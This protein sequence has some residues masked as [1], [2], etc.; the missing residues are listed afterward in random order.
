MT[1][2]IWK[3]VVGHE[4]SY[5]VSNLGRV[6]SL[7]RVAVRRIGKGP[8]PDRKSQYIIPGKILRPGKSSNG[9]FTVSI[10]GWSYCLHDL[11]LTAFRGPRPEA[12]MDACHDDGVKPNNTLGNLRWDTRKGNHADKIK[13]GT[14][15]RGLD[16]P[17]AKLTPDTVREIRKFRGK[18]SQSALASRFNVSP[19][20]VQ[21]VHDGRTWTHIPD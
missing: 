11:V 15:V 4:G 16:Y 17:T 2:E 6:R 21:A 3:P 9:Y 19:A 12:G 14:V 1:Q 8:N 18:L 13:H 10:G 5:D 20:A 7:E